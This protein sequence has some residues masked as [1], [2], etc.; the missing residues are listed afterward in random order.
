MISKDQIVAT[1]NEIHEQLEELESTLSISL[2]ELRNDLFYK[3][4]KSLKE[5]H[6]R[7]LIVEEE[8][9]VMTVS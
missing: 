9:N 1:L 2:N 4:E 7:L 3:H 6:K 8:L 5:C